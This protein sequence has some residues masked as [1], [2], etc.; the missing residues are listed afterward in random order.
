M[1]GYGRN[2]DNTG[3]GGYNQV[4]TETY[5]KGESMPELLGSSA[6]TGARLCQHAHLLDCRGQQGFR[7][8]VGSDLAIACPRPSAD[9]CSGQIIAR[10][11]SLHLIVKQSITKISSSSL[12]S[13]HRSSGGSGLDNLKEKVSSGPA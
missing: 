7:K 4:H 3:V 11:K 6:L 5:D 10:V 1:S 2:D 12:S 8:S 13:E 9:A